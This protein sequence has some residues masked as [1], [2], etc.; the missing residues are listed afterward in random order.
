M[1]SEFANHRSAVA[2]FPDYSKHGCMVKRHL[3]PEVS[4]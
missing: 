4:A 2:N 1:Y 3:T